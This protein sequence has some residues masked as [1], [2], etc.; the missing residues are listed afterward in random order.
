VLFDPQ[1]SGG[2]LIAVDPSGSDDLRVRLE[3]AGVLAAVVGRVIAR[4]DPETLLVVR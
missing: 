3:T 2:L 4:P 1:T